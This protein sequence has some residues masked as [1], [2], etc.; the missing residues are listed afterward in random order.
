MPIIESSINLNDPR[1]VENPAQN[2]ALAEE[3]RGRLAQ[4][5]QVGAWIVDPALSGC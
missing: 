5:R 2:R 1:F 4:V 3:L